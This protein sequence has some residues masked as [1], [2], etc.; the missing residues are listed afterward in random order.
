M[1]NMYLGFEGK[2][3]Q[4]TFWFLRVFKGIFGKFS[5]ENG[6][7]FFDIYLNLMRV[8]LDGA[9]WGFERVERVVFNSYLLEFGI[10]LDSYWS[11]SSY[12]ATFV[13]NSV[14]FLSIPVYLQ[15]FISWILIYFIKAEN[16]WIFFE[17]WLKMAKNLFFS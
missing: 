9:V 5:F 14:H 17:K 4:G 10:H 8:W 6:K 12:T 16:S 15:F 1:M 7:L 3:I 13:K 2:F 11:S